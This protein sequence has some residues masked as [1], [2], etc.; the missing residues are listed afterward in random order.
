VDNFLQKIIDREKLRLDWGRWGKMFVFTAVC[1]TSF[2]ACGGDEP[3]AEP[4]P[5]SENGVEDVVEPV[6]DAPNI[7]ETAAA[8][9]AVPEVIVVEEP[10]PTPTVEP[11]PEPPPRAVAQGEYVYSNGNKVRDVALMDNTIWAASTGGL[12]RYD[13]TTGEARKYTTLDGLPNIGIYALDVC[14]IDGQD[15]LIIGNRDGLVVYD[16]GGDSWEP[17]ETIGFN[18]NNA[19]HEMRCDNV[20]GRLILQHEDISILD[21]NTKTMTNYTEDED[22]LA[23]F[24]VEQIIVLGDDIWAPTD[25]KGISRIGLDGTVE[26]WNEENGFP[27]DDVSDIAIDSNG[28]YW[29]ALSDG[30]LKWEN[31]VYTLLDRETHPDVIDFFGPSHIETAVDNSLWLGFNSAL[32]QF[33][34]ATLA[35]SQWIDLQDDMGFPD[36]ASIARLEAL[37][38]GRILLHTYDEGAAYFDGSIWTVFALEN[39]AP[40]NFFDGLAQTNDGTIWAYGEGLYTTDLT[41]STWE[42]FPD[43]SIDDLTED[44]NGNV[45]MVSGKRVAQFN[46]A[47]LILL[48]VEDGLLDTVYNRIAVDAQG[49]VYAVG[50][51][52]YSIIDGESITAVGEA[53]G[54]D[55]GNIRDVLV[56]DGVVYAATVNGLVSITGD[57]WTQLLDETYVNLP[58]ENIGVLAHLSDGTVLLGTTRGLAR[59]KEGEVT[60]V[61]EVTGSISDI[62]VTSDDQIHVVSF[63]SS[64]MDGGY[65]HFDS[66][67]WNF[68]PDTNFPMTSLRAVMVDSDGTAW[69]GLGDTGLGGGIY[70]IAP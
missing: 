56:V 60:A 27:D 52:G 66:N 68:R 26:T 54:W 61:S 24:A 30:L 65:F 19:I 5:G 32:C 17:G 3:A 64:G 9:T 15:R 50:T 62:F 33:D 45:W 29:L 16:A 44:T 39:Q 4:Q 31:G 53:D 46:G 63:S 11:T 7:E 35:C 69:I 51:K 67:S 38:D 21:L 13:L 36:G 55:V 1:L 47:Q 6:A 48:E 70:R 28:I 23:W 2:A 20:N 58:D 12:V 40:T 8:P 37:P 18:S 59:Y 10:E 34:T 25:F 22:G 41:A 14:P 42:K 57:S 43:I 49:I